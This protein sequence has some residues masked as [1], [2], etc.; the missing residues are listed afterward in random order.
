[1]T[2][3]SLI[4]MFF[5]RDLG[6]TYHTGHIVSSVSDGIFLVQPDNM[7]D[8]ARMMPL[9]LVSIGD[10]LET[11]AQCT[12]SFQFFRSRI[13]LNAWVEWIETPVEPRV[14]S[15]VKTAKKDLQ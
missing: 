6:E 3:T 2:H 13:E 7:S 14:V 11:D 5:F 10:M 4:G 8:N 1:M 15:I 9:E 12:P